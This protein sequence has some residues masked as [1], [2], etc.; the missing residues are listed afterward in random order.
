MKRLITLL[1][2]A[3]LVLALAPAMGDNA[4]WTGL[5]ADNLWSNTNNWQ[6]PAGGPWATD[7]PRQVTGSEYF[8]LNDDT[9]GYD[10]TTSICDVDTRTAGG[11]GWTCDHNGRIYL[12]PD[13]KLYIPTGGYLERERFIVE[14]GAEIYITGG[15]FKPDCRASG[16][17][18]EISDGTWNA[19]RWTYSSGGTLHIKGSAPTQVYPGDFMSWSAGSTPT[20]QYTLDAGG[21]TPFTFGAYGSGGGPGTVTVEVAG[22]QAYLDGGGSDGDVI[23]LLYDTNSELD[24]PEAFPTNGTSVDG[25][26]GFLTVTATG[27]VVTVSAPSASGT[28]LIIR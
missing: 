16:F 22:I 9:P 12:N 11:D 24:Y 23:A 2:V 8:L 14:V 27:V 13:T 7:D 25:G 5:G 10:T 15:T 17:Y 1:A 3:G 19:S 21:V 28:L 6:D 20:L 26:L 18:M 4:T